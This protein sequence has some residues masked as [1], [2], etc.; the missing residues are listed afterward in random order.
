MI[1]WLSWLAF[2]L[3]VSVNMQS[4][5]RGQVDHPVYHHMIRR[6]WLYVID[7]RHWSSLAPGNVLML[8]SLD[9]GLHQQF[10]KF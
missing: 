4:A 3:R 2:E 8:I 6:L 10:S 9:Q 7:W 1:H 5:W